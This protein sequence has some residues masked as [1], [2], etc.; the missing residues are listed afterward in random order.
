M[1]HNRF[2]LINGMQYL[3]TDLNP[4]NIIFLSLGRKAIVNFRLYH[5]NVFKTTICDHTLLN[6]CTTTRSVN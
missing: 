1:V 2:L 3:P 6:D 4:M 5:T